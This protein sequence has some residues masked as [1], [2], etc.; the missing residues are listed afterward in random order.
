[1][2]EISTILGYIAII[3]AMVFGISYGDGGFDFSML[4]NFFS[5]SS[6]FITV[7]GTIFALLASFPLE[8]FKRIPGHMR[9]VLQKTR[10]TL[11]NT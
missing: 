6:I 8:S 11:S 3:G 7:G 4:Q 10:K 2:L 5:V 9:M 1:M